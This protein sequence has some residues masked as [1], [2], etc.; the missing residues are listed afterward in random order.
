ME[1]TAGILASYRRTLELPRE[2]R[3][4]ANR[5]LT[6]VQHLRR[7][8][9]VEAGRL[10]ILAMESDPDARVRE[11]AEKAFVARVACRLLGVRLAN[12]RCLTRARPTGFGGR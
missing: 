7:F 10:L 11:V 1:H 5:R 4:Q 8:E 2:G 12:R 9:D 3:R 6:I